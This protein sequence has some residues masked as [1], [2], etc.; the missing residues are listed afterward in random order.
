MGWVLGMMINMTNVVP[1]PEDVISLSLPVFVLLLI[2]FVVFLV[3]SISFLCHACRC[4]R[5]LVYE[6]NQL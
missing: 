3:I 4:R 5:K 6:V 1:V 2:L